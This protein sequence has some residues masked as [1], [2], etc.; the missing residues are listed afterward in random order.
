MI[1][2]IIKRLHHYHKIRKKKVYFSILNDIEDNNFF[3]GENRVFGIASHISFCYVGKYSYIG[4]G[5][6]ISRMK[7]G[8]YC[9]IASGLTLSAGRHPVDHLSTHSMFFDREFDHKGIFFSPYNIVEKYKYADANKEYFVEIGNDVWIGTN[10]LI[11]DG[12][13]IGDGAVIGASALVNKDVPPYAIVG[14]VPAR[15]IKYRFNR[16]IIDA[17][18][19]LKWWEKEEEWI[20]NQKDKMYDVS[21]ILYEDYSKNA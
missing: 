1:I 9:S 3:E 16:E 2:K 6:R 5:A 18:I 14:G 20:L 11:M 7:I 8:R 15:I 19:R 21:S 4:G 10:V 12:V 17:L 13:K